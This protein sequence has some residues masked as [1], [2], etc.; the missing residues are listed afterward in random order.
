MD[1]FDV[2]PF[3]GKPIAKLKSNYKF[4][5]QETTSLNEMTFN[6]QNGG[7]QITKNNQVLNTHVLSNF[8]NYLLSVANNYATDIL[9]VNNKIELTH[10][11]LTKNTKG[12]SHNRHCHPN[13]FFSMVYYLHCKSGQLVF[14]TEKSILQQTFNFDYQIKDYNIFNSSSWSINVMTND[15]VLFPGDMIHST[16]P[17]EHD[18]DRIVLGLNFFAKGVFGLDDNYGKL[19]L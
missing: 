7:T 19:E 15:M 11:W 12:N 4:S 3:S 18:E 8:K 1:N 10:S 14:D 13:I 17:N 9:G 6:H 2:I 16:T 5:N